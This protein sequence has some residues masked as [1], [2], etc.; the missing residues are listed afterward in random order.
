MSEKN[1]NKTIML[2]SKVSSSHQI[3]NYHTNTVSKLNEY[4]SKLLHLIAVLSAGHSIFHSFITSLISVCFVVMKLFFQ[5]VHKKVIK[6]K[7][8]LALNLPLASLF[9]N[10]Q[11]KFHPVKRNFC[12]TPAYNWLTIILVY[13]FR[14]KRKIKSKEID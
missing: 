6:I 5:P 7:K 1:T 10:A 3:A 8:W 13:I 12:P 9:S 4:I 14:L 11:Q 2:S